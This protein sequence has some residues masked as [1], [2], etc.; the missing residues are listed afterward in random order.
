MPA[1]CVLPPEVSDPSQQYQAEDHASKR[2]INGDIHRN[3]HAESTQQMDSS[4]LT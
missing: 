1:I 4:H 3:S 2:N